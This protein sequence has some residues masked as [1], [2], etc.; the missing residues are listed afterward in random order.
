MNKEKNLLIILMGPPGSGKGTQAEILSKALGL[1]RLGSSEIIK[2]KLPSLPTTKRREVEKA[3][4]S[5]A[6]I[7]VEIM[8][9]WIVEKLKKLTSLGIQGIVFDGSPRTLQEAEA[10]DKY[11]ARNK[12]LDVRVI[13]INI[14]PEESLQRRLHRRV[15][16]N[17]R[18]ALPFTPETVKMK[19]CPQCGGPLFTR[20]DDRNEEALVKRWHVFQALTMPVIQHYRAKKI[21][22]EVNGLGTI[23]EVHQRIM[24]ALNS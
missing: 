10:I 4:N 2:E 3:F 21:I 9:Q 19:T 12:T 18:H 8:S 24:E 15:C 16:D 20:K 7:P 22:K 23:E 6:L 14:P 17:C 1:F 11:L 5:G 13:F